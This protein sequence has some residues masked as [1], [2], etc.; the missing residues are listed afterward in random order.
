MKR[1]SEQ[2]Y[3]DMHEWVRQYINTY[4]IVRNTVMPGKVPGSVYTWMFYLRRGLF[5]A[6]FLSA[7]SQM[8]L[9]KM[10]QEFDSFEF[11]IAGLETAATPMVTGIPLVLSAF[12]IDLNGFV[13]RKE[14]KTYGLKNW[15]E[16][17]PNDKPIMLV[18]DLCN[19]GASMAKC[20]KILEELGFK[21]IPY[22]FTLVNKSNVGVHSEERLRTDLY[23]PKNFKMISLY[24]LDDFNLVNPSH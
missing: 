20:G 5:N 18:D 10:E 11:Q 21:F 19:S 24:T 14:R 8:F 15:I 13:V 22:A 1:I 23:L 2:Q 16:G 7:V 17:L 4:C 6:K 12:G 9:Y 3:K